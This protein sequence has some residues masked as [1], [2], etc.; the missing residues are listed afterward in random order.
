MAQDLIAT[1]FYES[2]TRFSGTME[3]YEEVSNLNLTDEDRE[4]LLKTQNECVFTWRTSDGW[5]IGIAMSYV[6]QD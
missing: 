5:P 3:N 2:G 4:M 1:N 6:W